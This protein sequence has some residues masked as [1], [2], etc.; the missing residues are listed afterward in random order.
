[1]KKLVKK[2]LATAL[3]IAGIFSVA[4]PALCSWYQEVWIS[5]E[6]VREFNEDLLDVSKEVGVYCVREFEINF[7]STFPNDDI[8]T[9]IYFPKSFGVPRFIKVLNSNNIINDE[10]K[11]TGEWDRKVE[12]VN[13]DPINGCRLSFT[14]GDKKI[15]FLFDPCFGGSLN[16][17][18]DYNK[19]LKNFGIEEGLDFENLTK[20]DIPNYVK[21]I[22]KYS[23]QGC[24]NLTKVNIPYSVTNIGEGAFLDCENLS[25]TKV[26]YSVKKIEEYAFTGCNSLR[27]L[28]I[29]NT[30]TSI[31]KYAF[32][33]SG[34]QKIRL[35]D[36]I[37]S[38]EEGTFS[39]CKY[40]ADIRIPNSV[41]NIADKAFKGCV[42][43]NTAYIPTSV[44]SIGG[45][46]FEDCHSLK[47]IEFNDK[48]YSSVDSFMQAFNAY[49]ASQER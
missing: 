22:G 38:I 5:G 13:E 7:P 45:N 27:E 15:I 29:P 10:G 41:T 4:P 49:R 36:S 18:S 28:Y 19:F 30:V 37:N 24:G 17:I 23:F 9:M 32:W 20:V 14:K 8:K 3:S 40:L 26:P 42:N 16:S 39:D 1:M 43:L 33:D 47:R 35:S 46:V 11:Y 34:L 48:L 12:F 44:T 6:K 2:T 21:S 31:G 25:E